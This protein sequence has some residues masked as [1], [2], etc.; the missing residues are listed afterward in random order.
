MTVKEMFV[1]ET[2]VEKLRRENE[3]LKAELEAA[4]HG[5]ITLGGSLSFERKY[6]NAVRDSYK[7]DIAKLKRA[8]RYNALSRVTLE[9]EE[10]RGSARQLMSRVKDE[11]RL[12]PSPELYVFESWLRQAFGRLVSKTVS[13]E[14]AFQILS[15]GYDK[16]VKA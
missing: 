5:N 8:V 3:R 11:E 10:M 6:G 13:D 4:K 1:S 15:S 12:H 7:A 16:E 14:V 2:V 9:L